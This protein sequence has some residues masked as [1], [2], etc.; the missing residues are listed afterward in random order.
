MKKAIFISCFGWYERRIKPIAEILENRDY[1][2]TVLVADF[3]QLRHRSR[4]AFT[5]S[6]KASYL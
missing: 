4:H 2:V 3:D 6:R 5:F 1:K